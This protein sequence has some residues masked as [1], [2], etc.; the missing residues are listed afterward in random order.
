[1]V[2][3]NIGLDIVFVPTLFSFTKYFPTI[4]RGY[5]RFSNVEVFDEA[6]SQ[7]L[8]SFGIFAKSSK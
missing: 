8:S 6:P 5:G 7:L 3:G 2:L 4:R 1:M